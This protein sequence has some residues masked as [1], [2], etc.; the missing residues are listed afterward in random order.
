MADSPQSVAGTSSLPPSPAPVGQRGALT[1]IEQLRRQLL[2]ISKRNRL[3]NTPVGKRNARQLEMVDERSEEVFRILWTERKKMTFEAAP[4]AAEDDDDVPNGGEDGEADEPAVFVPT[5]EAEPGNLAAHHVDRKLRNAL[6]PEALQKRLLALYRGARSIE[7]EQGVSVLYLALGFLRW[8]DSESSDIERA[9]PLILL[10]VDLERH[11]ARGRFRLV[12]RDQDL[13]VNLSL[14]AML[15]NDFALKLPDLPEAPDW[16]PSGYFRAVE[17][18]VSS[19]PRWRVDRDLMV[20]GFYSFAKFLMWRDLAAD[21]DWGEQGGPMGNPLASGL[22]TGGFEGASSA[23]APSGNLDAQFE[24]P[25]DLGHILDADASQTRVI[26]DARN[27]QSMVVQGPPGTG[28][29]QTI[30][31]V[32]AVA[33]RDGKRVLFVAEK[34]AALDVVHARLEACGL[35]PLCLELH[36]HKAI[37]RNVYG[38]LKRTLELGAP[39]AVDGANYEQ[40]RELRNEL[41]RLSTLLHRVDEVTGET[42]FNVMG[43]LALL[44]GG[45]ARRPDFT[46]EGADSWP[47]DEFRKK[48]NAIVGL[49]DLVA[50]QGSETEHLWRGAGRRLSQMDRRALEA[51]LGTALCA[52][53]AVRDELRRAAR[54]VSVEDVSSLGVRRE[55]LRRLGAFAVAPELVGRL[56]AREVVIERPASVAH[57]FSDLSR[58]QAERAALSDTVVEAAFEVDWSEVRLDLAAHGKSLFRWFSGAWRRASGRLRAVLREGPVGGHDERIRLVDRLVAYRKLRLAVEREEPLGREALSDFWRGETTD[59]S[60][61]MPAM[62]WIVAEAEA[63]GSGAALGAWFRNAPGDLDGRAAAKLLEDAAGRWANAFREVAATTGLDAS[64]AFGRGGAEGVEAIEAAEAVNAIDAVDVGA[65]ERRLRE[66]LGGM[67][68][69]EGWL[70]LAAAARQATEFGLDPIRRRLA[71]GRLEPGAARDAFRFLRAEAVWN[72]LRRETPEIESI[73]GTERSALVDRFRNLDARLQ[74]LAAQEVALR[75]FESIPVGAAGQIGIVRG[76]CNKKTRHIPLRKLLDL[77]GE[78]VASIKPV[79]LMSPLSVAQFLRPG[80]LTFDLLLIDEASQVRPADALGAVLRARQVIVVGDQQQLPPTSFF[81]R[82]VSGE[83]QEAVE[84]PDDI[85]GAQI[86]DMESILSL[87]EARAMRPSM[88]RWHYRSAHPSLITVSN[89]EFYDD[90]LIC[91]PSPS[92]AGGEFGL[93]FVPVAGVYD[94]GRRRNNP[95]EAE[96][97]VDEVLAHARD[98][99]EK[100]LGV[101]ALSVAQRD[102]IE[103][104]IEYMRSQAP[105]LDAFCNESRE[106]S[107]FVKNLENVQGDE[108][109][110]IFISIG[111]GKDAGGY[112]TQS[113]GPVSGAGGER[114]LN[115]LFTRA[116]RQCRVFSSIRYEDIRLDAAKHRGPRVLRRFLKYA[117]TGEMDVPLQEGRE[118]DSPFERAVAQA[119]ADHGH[120]VEAQVGSAGFRI[121]LAVRDPDHEG[122]FLLAVECDGA[123]YH[124]SSWARERD[125]LRQAVLEQKGWRFHRIWSTD[126]FYNRDAE[127]QKL[128]AAIDRARAAVAGRG[129]GSAVRPETAPSPEPS[130]SAG[131]GAQA[132]AG[133]AAAPVPPRAQRP[134][135]RRGAPRTAPEPKRTSYREAS[136]EI[137]GAGRGFATGRA[138][139]GEAAGGHD[140]LSPGSSLPELH[141]APLRLIAECVAKIVEVEGPVHIEEVGRRLS[142]LWGYKRAGSRIQARVAEAV[143]TRRQG[144]AGEQAWA[145]HRSQGRVTEAV[146]PLDGRIR[147]SAPAAARFLEPSEDRE[148]MVRDRSQVESATL[149]KVA[150]LPPT[151]V[152]AAILHAVERNIGI[153]PTDCAREV[154]RAMGFKTTSA[155]MRRFVANEAEQLVRDGRLERRG[156]ELRLVG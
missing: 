102:T 41:N 55:V 134:E 37:R 88:L 93:S 149:R 74:Y 105:A 61:S 117:E 71:D 24:D 35:G 56:L 27:G 1:A 8:Y 109:D 98:S 112:M 151:E 146:E 141:E 45:G 139:S 125:R 26:A 9:A 100:S 42:P 60:A 111:Y 83:D 130:P 80:G 91:P 96:A 38:E 18:A 50:E 3:T 86:G 101:V 65:L 97:I 49:A 126:W 145:T 16:R 94:R 64:V 20:L 21:N 6:T 135:V 33:A 122:R 123:R 31:N 58:L 150:M 137:P 153:T 72:R 155:D 11:N 84:D 44:D 75:H 148:V 53:G 73:E 14:G 62:S 5:G 81:D 47:R 57:L 82:Q 63:V 147:W 19:Q 7:E 143:G 76:E 59:L 144:E 85:F 30:A 23:D 131:S 118:M 13:D 69:Y 124:S 142:R 110:V 133:S 29:S 36:S 48:L 22:L 120:E 25:G 138:G 136:F 12:F 132:R 154:A 95:R 92:S 152:R 10:P 68:A 119:L 4:V 156:E 40:V 89:N 52:L 43:R 78:A 32:I 128:L 34:R 67:A 39:E 129:N 140:R 103:D 51:Q 79:F 107:F 113:F 127:V 28:K 2:D 87:C 108:R 46:V 15:Q 77:A 66:W 116:R 115:V 104:R 70:R 121:D 54:L 99:P 114:R 17:A 90:R 106:E